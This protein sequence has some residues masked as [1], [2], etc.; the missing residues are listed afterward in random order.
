MP[1]TRPGEL[2]FPLFLAPAS[3]ATDLGSDLGEGCDE[4]V[5]NARVSETSFETLRKIWGKNTRMPW[6]ALLIVL[7]YLLFIFK[8]LRQLLIPVA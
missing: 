6:L 1:T 3:E 7:N 8:S 4:T 5:V 2:V